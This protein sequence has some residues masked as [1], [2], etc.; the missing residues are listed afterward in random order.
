MFIRSSITKLLILLGSIVI[1]SGKVE[2]VVFE[3]SDYSPV[4]QNYSASGFFDIDDNSAPLGEVDFATELLDAQ[5]TIS[6]GT[7]EYVLDFADDIQQNSLNGVEIVGST[8][9]FST[10]TSG[11]FRM[12]NPPNSG[13]FAINGNQDWTRVGLSPSNFD[14]DSPS[15]LT[16]K[17]IPFTFSP[18]LGLGIIGGILAVYK[19]QQIGSRKLDNKS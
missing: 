10:A 8:L 15:I 19:L 18:T 1:N 4:D 7:N 14:Q 12:R 3:F 9:D 13:F 16:A 11:I 17:A 2:A 5:I 6:D